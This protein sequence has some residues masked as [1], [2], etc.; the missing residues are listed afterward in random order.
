L[1]PTDS[2]S[3]DQIKLDAGAYEFIQQN[4]NLKKSLAPY[5]GEE[6]NLKKKKK[7]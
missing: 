7:L 3:F 2:S 5:F 4:I 6:E 1:T